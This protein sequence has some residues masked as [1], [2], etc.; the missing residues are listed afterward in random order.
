MACALHPL[1]ALPPTHAHARARMQNLAWVGRRDPA[2]AHAAH[3]W[4]AA[5]MPSL[6]AH[7]RK[8]KGGTYYPH[9]LE[10]VLSAHELEWLRARNC[11]PI[12]ALQASGRVGAAA[13]PSLRLS[14]PPCPLSPLARRAGAVRDAAA[15]R[16]VRL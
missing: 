6:C 9:F 1:A 10:G 13:S 12:A 8:S 4:I 2:L 3:R 16:A 14:S 15:R 11:P 5:V 7:L